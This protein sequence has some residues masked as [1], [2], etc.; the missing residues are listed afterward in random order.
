MAIALPDRSVRLFEFPF[1]GTTTRSSRSVLYLQ[2]KIGANK[3]AS[4]WSG[5]EA[6][7]RYLSTDTVEDEVQG[8]LN[9]SLKCY[10]AARTFNG[11]EI[12]GRHYRVE[13]LVAK[14]VSDL[15]ARASASLGFDVTRAVVGRPVEFV[16]A[17]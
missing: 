13:D 1:A 17:Y 7:E 11:T 6:I 14:M 16:N 9:H 10:L 8:R 5:P 15:R 4:V 2:K 12:F 3:A